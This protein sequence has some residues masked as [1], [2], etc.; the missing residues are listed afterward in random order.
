VEGKES[1]AVYQKTGLA[2]S[3]LSQVPKEARISF[4]DG[5]NRFNRL[6]AMRIAKEQAKVREE[7]ANYVNQGQEVPADLLDKYEKT[8]EMKLGKSRLRKSE[9]QSIAPAWWQNAKTPASTPV[10][11]KPAVAAS[12]IAS[13]EPCP[14]SVVLKARPVVASPQMPAQNAAVVHHQPNASPAREPW[15]ASIT[16]VYEPQGALFAK[17]IGERA[18]APLATKVEAMTSLRQSQPSLTQHQFPKATEMS[19][20]VPVPRPSVTTPV[21]TPRGPPSRAASVGHGLFGKVPDLIQV[22]AT[23][24]QVQTPLAP[25]SLK[26]PMPRAQVYP[27]SV[28]VGGA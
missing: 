14:K 26:M 12:P 5:G 19:G 21:M 10:S 2:K 20:Q 9:M 8:I 3:T 1:T 6:D 7:A 24:A 15:D 23:R 28:R 18:S 13:V 4:E 11:T 17:R 25:G 27:G 22:A 16:T